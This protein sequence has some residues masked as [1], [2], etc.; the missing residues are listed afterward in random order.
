MNQ[1]ISSGGGLL[2]L[3]ARCGGYYEKP[4]G[5][6]LVGYAGRYDIG[7]NGPDDPGK[8]YVG[9]V[10]VN[11]AMAERRGR[12]MREVANSILKTHPDASDPEL[13]TGFAAAPEGGKALGE[14]LSLYTG[15]GYIY[16][17]K[18]MVVPRSSTTREIT[19]LVWKR[20]EPLPDEHWWIVE[21]VCNNFSTT[22]DMVDIIVSRGAQACGII[23]FLN[24]SP[25]V[26]NV[27][28]PRLDICLPVVAAIR[29]P[30]LEYRQD[31]PEVA[32]DVQ[33]GNVV[34]KPKHEWG[35]LQ[36]AMGAFD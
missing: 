5:G 36:A 13:N 32:A 10:Y 27:W 24:R 33:E 8:Q 9:K 7:L 26:E 34:W 11:F 16:P 12:V 21:D 4:S 31:D 30:I 3:L 35:K 22:L 2:A 25:S 17:E 28:S 23:C 1:S 20:H 6:P 19:R 18:E 15:R 14:A 29:K